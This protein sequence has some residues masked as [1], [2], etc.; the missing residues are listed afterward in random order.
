MQN[1][2][3]TKVLLNTAFPHLLLRNHHIFVD[4]EMKNQINRKAFLRAFLI[5]NILIQIC[6]ELGGASFE[7]NVRKSG[8]YYSCKAAYMSKSH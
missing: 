7:C 6:A 8:K 2:R 4:Q 3:F 5:F 1:E